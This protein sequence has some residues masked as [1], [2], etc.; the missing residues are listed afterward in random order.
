VSGSLRV[1]PPF[2]APTPP[3]TLPVRYPPVAG[4]CHHRWRH[5]SPAVPHGRPVHRH[6]HHPVRHPPSL[7]YSC[8][9]T[10][11]AGP[12]A[13]DISPSPSTSRYPRVDP[14]LSRR[15]GLGGCRAARARAV[16]VWAHAGAGLAET[17]TAAEKGARP[18]GGAF[19]AAGV[20]LSPGKRPGGKVAG[21]RRKA[22][23]SRRI[24]GTRGRGPR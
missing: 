7:N 1:A 12:A 15:A 10:G 13:H 24:S 6:H 21:E 4:A 23:R 19:A 17:A 18:G 20:F 3:H 8:A 5:R 2:P 11:A 9:R 14:R 16:A 22:R